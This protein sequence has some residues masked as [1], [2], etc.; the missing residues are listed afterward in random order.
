MLVFQQLYYFFFSSPFSPKDLHPYLAAS[1]RQSLEEKQ[2]EARS[3]ALNKELAR[4]AEELLRA[5]QTTTETEAH[6]VA[7]SMAAEQAEEEAK[8]IQ[9]EYEARRKADLVRMS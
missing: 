7:A 6:A 1:G 4:A 9:A 2:L 8:Q 5:S 3:A